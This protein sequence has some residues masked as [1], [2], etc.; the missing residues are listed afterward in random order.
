D[1]RTGRL[2]DR[3]ALLHAGTGCR[4]FGDPPVTGDALL[5]A[6]TAA[7]P[8]ATV[9]LRIECAVEGVGVDPRDPPLRWE[10]WTGREW[11]PCE[12]ERDETGGL[13]RPGDVL[14]GV[15]PGHT[16][17][18]FGGRAGGW[19]RCRLVTPGPRQHAYRQ[20]PR[21]YRIVAGTVGGT[22]SA[23][24]A[25][26]VENEI[27]GTSEGTPGQRFPLRHSPVVPSGEPP[28]LEVS[29]PAGWS[30][31]SQV[32]TF[33]FSGAGDPHFDLDEA[34]GEVLLGPA[35]RELD[36]TV[37][38]YGAIPPAGATLRLRSYR[39]GGG[40]E[41]N[42]SAGAISVLK[43]A[44]PFVT[45][46][47]NRRAATG[48]VAVEDLESAKARGPL[49]LRTHDRA[50]TASDYETLTRRV[51]PEIARVKCLGP[52]DAAGAVRVLVVPA[53]HDDGRG[54]LDVDAL[55]PLEETLERIA[56]HLDERR[57]VGT[58]VRVQ[59]P[60]YQAVTIVA[61]LRAQRGHS[62]RR[63]RSDA[64]DHLY[65]YYHPTTGGPG[66][67]GWPFGRPLHLGEVHGVLQ[68]VPGIDLVEDVRLF[69]ADPVTGERA[70]PVH[71]LDLDP[72][73][74]AYSYEHRVLVE[75]S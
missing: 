9:L 18:A 10:A 56:R 8:S 24:H 46:V 1:G 28:V 5:V 12:V 2:H 36:G 49:V 27:V 30:E 16:V 32:E 6:L 45:A 64:L 58:S 62:A 57:P 48:G 42:V 35:V 22:T 17:A 70:D 13:N 40:S 33:A 4:C 73:T 14:L 29:T 61:R 26:V 55:V 37:R 34:A 75:D 68:R 25:D 20:S 65:R 41:G 3:T 69:P 53:V 19:L 44:I 72:S 43:S 15:P 21:I 52:E 66:G 67:D 23:V 11:T 59:P 51:A 71:R 74:V 47:E 63:I 7:A 39:A 54:H 50:V 38:H 31:W 60:T